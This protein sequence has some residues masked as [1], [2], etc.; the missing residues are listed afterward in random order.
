MKVNHRKKILVLA[1]SFLNRDSRVNRQVA[2]IKDDY[3]VTALGFSGPEI[4]NV[5]FIQTE[6]H[7]KSLRDKLLLAVK[8]KT[9]DFEKI[10]WSDPIIRSAQRQLQ[11]R[12]FDLVIANDIEALPLACSLAKNFTTSTGISSNEYS[13]IFLP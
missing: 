1:F 2:F 6:Y 3:D 9:G 7:A 5:N 10:Y 12:Y 8:L 4:D 13:K 11:G